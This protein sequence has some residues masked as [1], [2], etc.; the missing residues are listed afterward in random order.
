MNFLPEDYKKP[1]TSDYMKLKEG[2]NVFRVLSSAIV[3]YK[4]W[5]NEDKPV[6]SKER[7]LSKPDDIKTEKDGSFRIQHFW[8]FLVWNYSAERVQV[9]EVPQSTIRDGM[10][11]LIDNKKWGDPKDYDISITRSGEGLETS[12]AVIPNP[13]SELEIDESNQI[14]VNSANLEA[15]Y[16]GKAVWGKE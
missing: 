14:K 9:L 8:A 15:L 2:E 1:E 3:G 5:T 10:Q 11:T 6:R 4:Y 7:I 16:E 12:Y 13:H